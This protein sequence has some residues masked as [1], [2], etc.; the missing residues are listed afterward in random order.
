MIH[1]DSGLLTR[2]RNTM[3]GYASARV[4]KGEPMP[5]LFVVDQQAPL[6][7]ILND[8]EVLAAASAMDEWSGQ[9]IFVPL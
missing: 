4:Q 6:G 5:G 9:V 3:T 2:D 7:R 8:L 1:F